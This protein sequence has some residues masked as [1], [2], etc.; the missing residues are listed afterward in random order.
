MLS[1]GSLRLPLN[2]CNTIQVPKCQTN[3]HSGLGI[4]KYHNGMGRRNDPY[5]GLGLL[6]L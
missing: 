5:V 1:S 2:P 4:D 6:G 3:E